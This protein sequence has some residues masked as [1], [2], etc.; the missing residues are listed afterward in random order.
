[1]ADLACVRTSILMHGQVPKN[2]TEASRM[3]DLHGYTEVLY[4]LC[5]PHFYHA[6]CNLLIVNELNILHRE[7]KNRIYS[8]D[9]QYKP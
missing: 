2:I 7:V 1:M 3:A 5:G 8:V 6:L 9:I 4:G